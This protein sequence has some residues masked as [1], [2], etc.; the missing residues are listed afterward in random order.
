MHCSRRLVFS[1]CMSEGSS[2]VPFSCWKQELDFDPSPGPF[3]PPSC[4][5][6]EGLGPF[7][8]H[9]PLSL[10]FDGCFEGSAGPLLLGED[11]ITGVLN[12]STSLTNLY[13]SRAGL[14]EHLK[15]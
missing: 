8:L 7:H 12:F 15:S 3:V 2:S 10:I 13:P 1:W 14:H 5:F 9:V 4:P 6:C 11:L